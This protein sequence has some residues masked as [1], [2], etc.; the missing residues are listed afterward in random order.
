L[1]TGTSRSDNHISSQ[2]VLATIIA[3][4]KKITGL[5]IG[6]LSDYIAVLSFTQARMSEGYSQLPR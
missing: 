6:S 3:D 5:T 4:R 1:R 2:F